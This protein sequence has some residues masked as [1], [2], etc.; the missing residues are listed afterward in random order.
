MA[1]S[2]ETFE[3]RVSKSKATLDRY[4]NPRYNPATWPHLIT[5]TIGFS[6]DALPKKN[7][8]LLF[9]SDSWHVRRTDDPITKPTSLVPYGYDGNFADYANG[10]YRWRASTDRGH[11]MW[12]AAIN[13]R[14]QF[15]AVEK[16]K[17]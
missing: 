5:F 16:V 3:N 15:Y 11:D 2:T 13:G 4:W 9:D 17:T 12:H 8:K 14:G 7:Y 6:T 10:T 1:L